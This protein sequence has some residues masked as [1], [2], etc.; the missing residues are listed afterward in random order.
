MAQILA[1]NIIRG[2]TTFHVHPYSACQEGVFLA[3]GQV[4]NIYDAPVKTTWKTGAFQVGSTQKAVKRLHRDMV[5]GFHVKET[6][7][8][9]EFNDS[10]FRRMFDYQID[11]L[12]PAA[13]PTT[14]AVQTNISGWRYIDVLLHEQPEFK[15]DI[16]PIQDQYGN[17]ILKLRAGRPNWRSTLSDPSN[18]STSTTVD[19][20]LLSTFSSTAT[21]AS[22]SVTVANPTDQVMYQKWII[23]PCQPTL[24]D[25]QWVG[26][27]N[28]RT[29]GGANGTRTVTMAPIT[30]ANGGAVVDLDGSNLMVRDAN[31]TNI[32]G[33]QAG[34]F[35]NYPIPPYTPAT[36]LPVSY[37]GA[38]SGGAMIQLV[39]PQ[40]WSRPWGLELPAGGS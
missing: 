35:F 5:L 25:F 30:V 32:L 9:Y 18:P 28:F 37:Q 26:V 29:P 2:N 36:S 22:G 34:N 7:N 23:T 33:Q 17:V 20:S 16:D 27:R 12:D 21:A 8:T 40:N 11:P 1:V 19:P 31:N 39:Q 4:D 13:T 14:I 6:T 15:A 3:E 10:A 24:P 38:P